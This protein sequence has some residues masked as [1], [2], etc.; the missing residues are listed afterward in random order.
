MMWS[1]LFGLLVSLGASATAQRQPG[2]RITVKNL[3]ATT[4]WPGM[5]T[6]D[7]STKPQ[8][9]TGWEAKPASYVQF[10]VP[11]NWTAARIWARTGCTTLPDGSFSC[12]TGNCGKGAVGAGVGGTILW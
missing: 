1:V 9:P 3:C 5:Y 8:Q 7:K 6:T 10:T 11:D 2:R 12:L 4:I